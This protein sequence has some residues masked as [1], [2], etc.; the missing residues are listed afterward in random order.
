MIDPKLFTVER[1]L[2]TF[3]DDM[4]GNIDRWRKFA[5]IETGYMPPN[6]RP[7]TKPKCVVRYG[8]SFLRYSAGPGMGCFWDIYGDDFL[9]AE[10]AFR[11]LLQAPVPPW[12]CKR[13]EW[14]RWCKEESDTKQPEAAK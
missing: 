7:E 8:A 6:P 5:T 14:E 9:D 13:E 1:L 3:L 12:V 2:A 10:L 11:A 4:H